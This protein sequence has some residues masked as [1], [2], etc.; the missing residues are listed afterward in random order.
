MKKDENKKKYFSNHFTQ[1]HRNIT[2]Y[3]KYNNNLAFKSTWETNSSNLIEKQNQKRR[4]QDLREQRARYLDARRHRL[5]Q[6]LSFEEEMYKQ[7]IIESQETPEQVRDRMEQKLKELKERKESERLEQ[8]KKLQERRFVEGAD[9]LRKCDSEAF[10]IECYLEQE[11]QMLDKLKQRETERRKE[12]IYVKLNELDN[13][14]K[15]KNFVNNPFFS[16]T[17][18]KNEGNKRK[19]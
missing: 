2:Q 5:A 12:E 7:E 16:G 13:L 18:K 10:A 8:V 15:C 1:N 17:R 6:L 3:T 14:K 19:T 9:E 4:L 11:N